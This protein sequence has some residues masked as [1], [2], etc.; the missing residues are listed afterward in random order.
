MQSLKGL[1]YE[2]TNAQPC[3]VSVPTLA[4]PHGPDR[5][6]CVEA[7]LGTTCP[8]HDCTVSVLDD[9]GVEQRFLVSCQ[10]GPD[11]PVNRP[12]RS[13]HPRLLWGGT[14]LVM[15]IGTRASFVNLGTVDKELAM[16][17]VLK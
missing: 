1:L 3:F 10:A 11:L 9:D 2:V 15:K 12:I 16:R 4:N 5:F 17:S 14:V 13:L 7:V 8:V 6:P